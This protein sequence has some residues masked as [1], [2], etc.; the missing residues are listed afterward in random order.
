MDDYDTH[1]HAI[2]VKL[3]GRADA[4]GLFYLNEAASECE[5][6]VIDR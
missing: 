6:L 3:S 5:K 2:R 4:S 1:L